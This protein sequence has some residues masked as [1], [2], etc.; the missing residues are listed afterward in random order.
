MNEGA[1]RAARRPTDATERREERG[2]SRF[3][4]EGVGGALGSTCCQASPRLYD[5]TDLIAFRNWTIASDVRFGR[6]EGQEATGPCTDGRRCM[7]RR[8]RIGD[9]T[10]AQGFG[11]GIG[12]PGGRSLGPG[13]GTGGRGE[14]GPLGGWPPGGEPKPGPLGGAIG[15]PGGWTPGPLP[16]EGFGASIG[17]PGSRLLGPS[18]GRGAGASMGSSV[19]GRRLGPS[20]GRPLGSCF[21]VG[22]GARFAGAAPGPFPRSRTGASVGRPPGWD[23]GAVGL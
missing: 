19:I 8:R 21:D 15:G 2:T 23:V 13:P 1:K 11:G 9:A 22:S 18:P 10:Q 17:L 3:P 16:G 7:G 12:G 5:A 6:L 14:I 4:Q 20:E